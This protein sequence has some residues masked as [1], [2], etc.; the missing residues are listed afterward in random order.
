MK[1]LL[2]IL[3][4]S[5]WFV[6]I[7]QNNEE[8]D[9]RPMT[10][11]GSMTFEELKSSPIVGI[12][13]DATTLD[14]LD[15]TKFDITVEVENDF[16]Y[17]NPQLF[18]EGEKIIINL[19]PRGQ[20]C[21]C[22]FPT[23]L[24]INIRSAQKEGAFGEGGRHYKTTIHPIHITVEKSRAWLPRCLWVIASIV[25]LILLFIY[26]NALQKKKRFKKNAI[27]SPIYFDRYGDE[28]DNHNGTPLRKEGIA[29][30]F[31]RWFVPGNETNTLSFDTPLNVSSLT[32]EASDSPEVI[33]IPKSDIDPDTMDIDGY[34]PEN[35]RDPSKQVKLG[36]NGRI[37]ISQLGSGH[38]L[39][40]LRFT[41]NEGNDGG[42]Y[43]VFLT[44]VMVA[45]IIG[46]AALLFL[47]VKS[48]M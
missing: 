20:W 45:S 33:N 24:I 3:L 39:G 28:V 41:S 17:Q 19:H 44:I 16:L 31:V 11:F 43:R 10:D 6:V 8:V 12:M 47:M 26:A 5:S 4:L 22:I 15:A 48:F 32:I 40:Y 7:A 46:I 14:A 9:V 42:G 35:D 1:K 36:N 37:R 34:D 18:V 23:N 30:W 13:H 2:T 29:S 25:G 38:E 21:E 27:M